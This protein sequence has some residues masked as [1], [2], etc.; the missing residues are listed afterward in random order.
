MVLRFVA[1]Q[2]LV[3]VRIVDDDHLLMGSI[4]MIVRETA[5]FLGVP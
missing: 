4:D 3:S 1:R 5:A 2:P